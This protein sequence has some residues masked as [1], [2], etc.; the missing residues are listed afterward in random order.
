MQ[1]LFIEF[2]PPWVETGLQPA[3]YD[4]ES[5]T[6]LQQTA[7]M[8]A[9]VNELVKAVN[10][11]D[12]VVKE[13]VDYIDHY[14]D[15][16]D[17]QE[18]VD[19]KLEDMNES[20]ELASI[21]SLYLQLGAMITFDTV[22]DM[23]AGTNLVNGS[24]A[25]TLGKDTYSDGKGRVYKIRTAQEGDVVD[26]TNIIE[27]TAEG[28]D[29]L[30]AELIPEQI[31]NFI[32]SLQSDVED[33]EDS[34]SLLTN[35]KYIFIGD[36]YN[37]TDTPSGGVPIVPWSLKVRD[38][39]GLTDGVN[40]FRSGVSGAGWV[41]GTNFLTQLQGLSIADKNSITD[42]VV[43]G[44]I[45]DMSETLSDVY[46]AISSFAS[47]CASNYPNAIVH[48]GMISWAKQE[49]ARTFLRRVLPYW[50]STTLNFANMVSIGN[51]HT[52]F[53]NYG[54]YQPDGHPAEA[55]SQEIARQIAN[56]LKGGNPSEVWTTTNNVQANNNILI[57][58]SGNVATVTS[59]ID[60]SHVY[61]KFTM[62]DTL[63]Y[64]ST[65]VVSLTADTGYKIGEIQGDVQ[66]FWYNSITDGIIQSGTAYIYDTN[67]QFTQLNYYIS[68]VGKEVYLTF[69]G[70]GTTGSTTVASPKRIYLYPSVVNTVNDAL[71]S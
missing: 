63:D 17:V 54:Y 9:K 25:K 10:G 57:T 4:K 37:T 59:T 66:Y 42:I 52:F 61:T 19:N 53:H 1:D 50:T 31:Y 44:G 2:L 48:V 6:V 11:M 38:Y 27:I 71:Y 13:Y 33:I 68:C 67:N 3:F 5:G 18:E 70:V 55:G 60:G 29:N 14:F 34:L 43:C 39:M 36:S 46:T 65:G 26:G 58:D 20:G 15:T 64:F 24:T 56:H 16:L 21:I 30:V 32:S 69:K 23:Q 41:H 45:N 40:C 62:K 8:Y 51:A 7:R 49:N 12:K 47:Y 28:A 35:K 22:S